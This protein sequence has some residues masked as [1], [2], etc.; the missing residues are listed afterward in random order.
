MNKAIVVV[1]ASYWLYYTIFGA[2]SEFQKKSSD[3]ARYWIKPVEE[4]DQNNLPDLLNCDTFKRILTKFVMKRC[5][6]IDWQLKS[7]FQDKLDAIDRID[8]VFA[9]DD[10]VSKNFRKTL[11]PEYKAQR[12][13]AP[14]AYN[15]FNI[16]QYVFDVIFKE[17]ELEEKYGYKFISV[18][19]AEGDDV[20]ATIFKRCVD[21]YDL[22]VL[23]ASD[24][25]FVQLKDVVQLNLF[26]QIVECKLADENV[27]PDEY[28]L[29]KIIL[30]DGSDNIRKVFKGVGPKKALK[31]IRDKD[32]L[33]SMLK[34]DQDS[35]KQFI[36]NRKLI[37]FDEILIPPIAPSKFFCIL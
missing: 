3:E 15:V 5:E 36:L 23:F 4:V 29:S 34:E 8:I 32:K 1:D 37:S 24:H 30:G 22:K 10:Y 7:H 11:Y 31:L 2:V 28:L 9:M 19:G 16:K 6:T 20:I 18:E 21:D 25:D 35:A 17:L 13:I 33:K 14:K 12:Q 26:G 27:T